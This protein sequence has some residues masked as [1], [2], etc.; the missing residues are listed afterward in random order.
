MIL[1]FKDDGTRDIFARADTRDARLACPALLW[2]VARRKLLA[3]DRAQN[4]ADLREPPGNRLERLKGD[5][6]GAFSIRVN[7]RYRVCFHWTA[8]GPVE[9]E[10]VDYR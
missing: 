5:R 8:P 1:S 10:I 6:A 2:P 7:E 3:I 9:V 4:V